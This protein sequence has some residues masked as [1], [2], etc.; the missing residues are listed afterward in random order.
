MNNITVCT[1]SMKR[2]EQTK[3]FV[4]AVLKLLN[5][6]DELIYVDY[7][8]YDN[9]QSEYIKS[10][11]DDRIVLV[12]V[13]DVTTWHPSHARNI[14]IKQAQND[15]VFICDIDIVPSDEIIAECRNLPTDSFLRFISDTY[16]HGE[17]GSCCIWRK[18]FFKVNGYEEALTHWGIEDDMFFYMLKSNYIKEL[19]F[20]N[21]NFTAL[22]DYHSSNYIFGADKKHNCAINYDIFMNLLSK[23]NRMA[24]VNRNWGIAEIEIVCFFKYDYNVMYP[25]FNTQDSTKNFYIEV[26]LGLALFLLLMILLIIIL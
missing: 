10:L 19:I 15:I 17:Y 7:D 9:R 5:S 14:S 3:I 26:G 8:G 6:F 25:D 13:F 16:S 18:D 12:K 24:N 11:N 20:K 21:Q 23:S 4:P 22:K 1:Y 2:L